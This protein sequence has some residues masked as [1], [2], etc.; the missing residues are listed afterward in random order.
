MHKRLM[1]FFCRQ[2]NINS[3]VRNIAKHSKFKNLVI[4]NVNIQWPPIDTTPVGRADKEHTENGS[5]NV[6]RITVRPTQMRLPLFGQQYPG[7]L[8]R[9]F[10]DKTFF[11]GNCKNIKSAT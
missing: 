8:P 2:V 6:H 10:A 5:N 1:T 7:R 3:T 9:F 4:E 11:S